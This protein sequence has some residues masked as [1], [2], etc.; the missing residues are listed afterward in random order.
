MEHRYIK[1][2]KEQELM[3]AE[4]KAAKIAKMK[5]GDDEMMF[6]DVIKMDRKPLSPRVT[7]LSERSRRERDIGDLDGELD[8]R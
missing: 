3:A 6:G 8:D 2:K 7:V 5:E 1:R 4:M